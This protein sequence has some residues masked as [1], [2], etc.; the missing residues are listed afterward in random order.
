MKTLLTTLVLLLTTILSHAQNSKTFQF[1]GSIFMNYNVPVSGWYALDVKGAQGGNAGAWS[2][3]YGAQVGGY[4]FFNQGD[5]VQIAVGGKGA[6]G[7]LEQTAVKLTGAGGGGASSVVVITG[8]GQSLIMMAG[9]GGGASYS[10][11]GK[12]GVAQTNGTSGNTSGGNSS[13]SGGVNSGGGGVSSDYY[14]GG[15]GA[16]YTNDGGTHCDGNCNGSNVMAFGGQAYTSGNLGGDRGVSGYGCRGGWGGGGEGGAFFVPSVDVYYNGGGGG[17]GGYSG[18]GGGAGGDSYAS[19]GGGGS[20]H[21]PQVSNLKLIESDGVNFGDGTVTISGP[22]LSD[23]DVDQVVDEMDNC[24]QTYNPGQEDLNNDGVGDACLGPVFGY[25]I[26]SF[27]FYTIANAGWYQLEAIGA[28]GGSSGSHSGGKGAHMRAMV[29]LSQGDILKIAVGGAG[30]S[31][32]FQGNNPSGGGG[33]GATSIVKVNGSVNTPLLFAAGGGGA[34]SNWDGSPGLTSI[35]GQSAAGSG[36]TNGS[37]GGI[38]SDY[39]GGAGGAGYSGDGG[40]HYDRNNNVLSYGGQAYT[41]GNYGGNS[42]QIGGDGGWG[43][44]GEG[45]PANNTTDGGGGGGGGYS[46]GGGASTG[47]GGGGGGSYVISTANLNGLSQEEG[48]NN[49]NGFAFIHGPYFDSDGDGYYDHTD[50]CPTSPNSNQ[51]DTD[52]D[53]VGDACDACPQNSAITTPQAICGCN[54]PERDVDNNGVIDCLE[55]YF[56]YSNPEFQAFVVPSTNWYKLEVAGAQGGD[57][58]IWKGMLGAY[59]KG[60]YYLTQGQVLR[61]GVGQ[62]GGAGTSEYGKFSGGGGGG[63]SSVAKIDTN[64]SSLS[65][66]TPQ[67]VLFMV[68]GGGGGAGGKGWTGTNYSNNTPDADVQLYSFYSEVDS[69]DYGSYNGYSIECLSGSSSLPWYNTIVDNGTKGFG[70]GCAGLGGQAGGGGSASTSNCGNDEYDY[71]GAGGAGYFNAGNNKADANG[72]ILSKGGYAYLTG[73]QTNYGGNAGGTGGYGGY[74]G[75]GQGGPVYNS[76]YQGGGGGG[77]G[78][79]GGGGGGGSIS[80]ELPYGGG[81][82]G[83]GGSKII[84]PLNLANYVAAKN[85]E[86]YRSINEGDG[87]VRITMV[88]DNDTDKVFSDEDNCDFTYNPDQF[89]GDFDGVGNACDPCPANAF[90]STSGPGPCGC[91]NDIADVNANGIVDCE[92]GIFNNY[93]TQN[94]QYIVQQSGWY[95]LD[96][97]GAQGG[98]IVPDVNVTGYQGGKGARIQGWYKL[99]A[100]DTLEFAVGETGGAGDCGSCGLGANWDP[101]FRYVWLIQPTGSIKFLARNLVAYLSDGCSKNH[102]AGAGGGGRSLVFNRSIG[103]ELLVAGGGGGAGKIENGYDANLGWSG[104]GGYN[105][106]TNGQGGGNDVNADSDDLYDGAGGGGLMATGNNIKNSSG[107][108]AAFGGSA[109][110]LDLASAGSSPNM[111]GDGGF[112]GGGEGGVPKCKFLNSF[113]PDKGSGGGGGGGGYSGGGSGEH[114]GHGGGGG[115]SYSICRF[116]QMTAGYRTGHG[117]ASIVGP[118]ADSDSDNV[119]D[120]I[121]KCPDTPNPLQESTVAY[122]GS[123]TWKDNNGSTIGTYTD[124]GNYYYNDTANCILYFLRL[125]QS[126][127]SSFNDPYLH[128]NCTA[129]TRYDTTIV[130]CTP[131]TWSKTG[132]TYSQSEEDSIR[133]NCELWYIHLVVG[134]PAANGSVQGSRF[135]CKNATVTYSIPPAAGASSYQWTLPPLATGSSTTNSITVVFPANFAGGQ[136]SVVPVNHCGIG[137]AVT[138]PIAVVNTAPTGALRITSPAA[139][140]VSGT[141]SVNAIAGANAYTW[142]VSSPAATIVSGQGTGSI[143]LQVQSGYTGTFVLQVVASNCKGKGSRATRAIVVRTPVRTQD[144]AVLFLEQK[145]MVFPNPNHGAFTVKVVPFEIDA[146]LEVYSMDGRMVCSKLVPANTAE[147]PLDL[148]QPAAGLYQVRVVAGGEVR[149]VKVVV[150]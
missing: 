73:S 135:V 11:D 9:G 44:G 65:I 147:M 23:A 102:R 32:Q 56:N 50:N 114:G 21:S 122:S 30:G 54:Q 66:P 145:L 33:G 42:G 7:V 39:R 48:V 101:K 130:V 77:G 26:N 149:S 88:T 19:G 18:G 139:P 126:T 125:R 63:A 79:S 12:P 24:P 83:R 38:G 112:G 123:Y 58:G 5:E 81:F 36:G 31:G 111:G 43:G 45:G 40:S 96:V 109:A 129:L 28:Q 106:G 108:A 15:G 34:G 86:L 103:E 150:Q 94:Q 105:P 134:P 60:Y 133:I 84:P 16:G 127:S 52:G 78:Y 142:S 1:Q 115:G 113:D 91:T 47:N 69:C 85:S 25:Q 75:G 68:A 93:P 27:Q 138:M 107:K 148:N 2:G 116:T 46:G 95:Y 22:F 59:L 110:R 136:L 82:G 4:Y 92:E 67:D 49:G 120:S 90:Y 35:N 14:G 141:Y 3:G 121:D 89:D 98:Y 8:S 55:G 29:Q 13:G 57:A 143:D 17:G 70:G 53:R 140:A 72:S 104:V 37:G 87:W 100:N 132:R 6:D 64:F 61:I 20:Y 146:K 137:N 80:T 71:D 118:Y 74:G 117:T 128:S 41:S 62:K 124:P 10:Q 144:P 97:C 51:A 131:F 119:P 99:N 76:L